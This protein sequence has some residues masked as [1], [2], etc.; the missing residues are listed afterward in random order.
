M[1]QRLGLVV[2]A[3]GTSRRWGGQDKTAADLVGRPVLVRVLDGAIQALTRDHPDL[4]AVVVADPAHAAREAIRQLWP[5]LR[6]TREVPIRGG[7]VAGLAA[8]LEAL[9]GGCGRVAVLAG[10]LPFAGPA[11][12]RLALDLA[13]DLDPALDP[14]LDASPT[15]TVDAVV[16]LDPSGR[17]QPLLAAY[18]AARLQDV[19]HRI[20]A[21]AATQGA[22]AGRGPALRDVLDRLSV[23]E[24]PVSAREALDLD[25][26]EQLQQA[27]RLLQDG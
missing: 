22:S 16:G 12:A 24:S 21:A 15:G 7:P 13:L 14:A 8:G 11:I 27:A 2:L 19:L 1:T 6:W 20:T 17:R 4:V 23:R 10:D 3:G 9:R 25:T 18:R 26:A 5:E